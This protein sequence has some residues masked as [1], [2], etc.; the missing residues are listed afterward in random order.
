MI[1]QGRFVLRDTPR[2]PRLVERQRDMER[3]VFEQAM[4]IDGRVEEALRRMLERGQ[5]TPDTVVVTFTG[6]ATKRAIMVGDETVWEGLL[7]RGDAPRH[8][9][10][11]R[12]T[13]ECRCDWD[14]VRA[15]Q[16][17][18]RERWL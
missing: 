8:V 1:P 12:E 5:V 6:D 13:S 17:E 2:D 15:D 4:A 7:V 16:W 10:R 9:W 3:R 14:I 18:W 11:L